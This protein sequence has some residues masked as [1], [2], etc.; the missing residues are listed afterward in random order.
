MA[1]CASISAG[2]ICMNTFL[3]RLAPVLCTALLCTSV[4]APAT[5]LAP[6]QVLTLAVGEERSAGE[7]ARTAHL[8]GVASMPQAAGVRALGV[9]KVDRVLLGQDTPQD[10]ALYAWP[11]AAAVRAVRDDPRYVA[12]YL[13]L[14]NAGWKQQR[15]LD[16]TVEA[17]LELVFDHGRPYTLALL[18]LKDRA[19]YDRYYA[20]TA[21]L[22][23]RLGVRPVLALPA[24]HYGTSGDGEVDPPDLVLLFRWESAASIDAYLQSPEFQQHHGHFERG[25]QRL[26][27]YRMGVAD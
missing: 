7:A 15:I 14:R 16:L 10:V 21:G 8:G 27:W 25:V 5:N 24:Q 6:G 20:G 26:E 22:R 12:D 1:Q 2:A 18:W 13:P 4:T 23:E 3:R 19:E 9:L 17:P 11:D